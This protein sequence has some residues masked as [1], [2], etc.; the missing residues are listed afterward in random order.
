[1]L[2]LET[3]ARASV[4]LKFEAPHEFAAVEFYDQATSERVETYDM[5]NANSW[6]MGSVSLAP[7]KYRIEAN[8]V[9]EEF[10]LKN[11]QYLK[12]KWIANPTKDQDGEPPAIWSMGDP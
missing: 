11:G 7:G 8:G 9:A 1:M 2:T 4:S 6:R 10:E 12:A 3:L 5:K